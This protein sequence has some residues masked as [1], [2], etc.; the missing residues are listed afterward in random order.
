MAGIFNVMCLSKKTYRSKQKALDTLN[1]LR[2]NNPQLSSDIRVYK[3]PLC[4]QYHLGA[5]KR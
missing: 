3:C 1:Y 2:E 4:Q 5:K